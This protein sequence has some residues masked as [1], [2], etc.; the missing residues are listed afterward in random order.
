MNNYVRITLGQLNFLVGD[1]A[2]NTQKIIQAIEHTRTLKSHVL[3]LPELALTGYSPEDLLF[4][5]EFHTQITHALETI[6]SHTDGFTVIL[7]YPHSTP[8]GIYNSAAVLQNGH[9]I[10]TYH[11]QH[12]PNYGVFDE[13]RYFIPGS[14]SC[15][16]DI[17]GLAIGLL[18]CE[19]IWD[20]S[21]IQNTILAGAQ[22]IFCLNASPFHLDKHSDRMHTLQQRIAEHKIP[23]LYVNQ[24]GTQDDI[25]FD[26]DSMLLNAQGEIIAHATC[27]EE[28]FLSVDLTLT[29]NQKIECTPQVLSAFPDRKALAYQALTLGVRDYVHKNGF[30]RVLIG[31][32]G[33]IDSALTLALAVDALGKENVHA[34]IMP[35]RYTS[36]LSIQM[37]ELQANTQGVRYSTISI[38]NVFENFLLDLSETFTNT[39]PDITEE[40]LQARCR[41]VIL[42]ALSNKSGDLVLTTGNKSELA[43]GYSTLYGDM[44]GGFCVLKDLWKTLVFD[45]ARYRNTLSPVIPEPVINRAPTAELAH[46]QKD[47]DSLPPY[48]ILDDILQRYVEQNHS[49]E[50]IIAEG[51]DADTVRHTVKLLLRNEYKR[52]QSPP[53]I[54]ITRCAFGRDRRYPITSGFQP[55]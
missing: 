38:D 27:F 16:I 43:V 44:A 47:E 28:Q 39:Q 53:G 50:Q 55:N 7:G 5:P 30:S 46:D 11:K 25:I 31:L 3:V 49:I 21:P 24:I 19:D 40:N 10:T 14:K 52:R 9:I 34:V 33:G 54:K 37:A 8:H 48:S 22:A 6:A 18:I 4:R 1:I 2:G 13:K 23:I 12:L 26:G 41:A 15:V 42:M 35:S 36:E 20:P 32:S 51:F 45:L 29:A 17:H